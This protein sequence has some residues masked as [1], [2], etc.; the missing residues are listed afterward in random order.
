VKLDSVWT[1][2]ETGHAGAWASCAAGLLRVIPPMFSKDIVVFAMSL[3]YRWRVT[4]SLVRHLLSKYRPILS[5]IEVEGRG[6]AAPVR[7]DNWYRFIPSR[8]TISRKALDKFSQV[9]FHRSLWHTARPEGFSRL[10]LRQEILRY[11]A[12]QGMFDMASMRSG[13]LYRP[14]QL[15]SFLSEGQTEA[16]K[17]DEFLGRIITV[18]MALRATDTTI[19]TAESR[20]ATGLPRATAAVITGD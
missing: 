13:A 14:E 2:R 16:F 6:P 15:A 3:D 17:Q 18:E 11:T 8:L 19:Q 5:N 10:A 7:I 12:A 20:P 4:N 9:G 1:Y